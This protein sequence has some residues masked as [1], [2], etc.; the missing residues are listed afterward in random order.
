MRILRGFWGREERWGRGGESSAGRCARGEE[1]ERGRAGIISGRARIR[2]GDRDGRGKERGSLSASEAGIPRDP[3]EKDDVKT[4]GVFWGR[5]VVLAR[6]EK[7]TARG[8]P[9]FFRRDGGVG[10]PRALN[11]SP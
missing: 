9:R 2:R 3:C 5:I 1:I 8:K 4:G 11:F 7:L 10:D 6:R